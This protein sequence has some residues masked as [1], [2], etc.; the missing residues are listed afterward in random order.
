MEN[1]P[2]FSHKRSNQKQEARDK[3]L[4]ALASHC[5]LSRYVACTENERIV[6][7]KKV[8][9]AKSK[10]LRERPDRTVNF[11][12]WRRSSDSHLFEA[13]FEASLLFYDISASTDVLSFL[14]M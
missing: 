8:M 6:K 7:A 10:I 9:G 1:T 4:C 5:L 13:G 11:S 2:G 3:I 14:V 12:S